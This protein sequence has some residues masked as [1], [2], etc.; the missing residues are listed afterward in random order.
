MCRQNWF[1]YDLR[2]CKELQ[3]LPKTESRLCFYAYKKY[4]NGN[5]ARRTFSSTSHPA[6]HTLRRKWQFQ[7]GN[8]REITKNSIFKRHFLENGW[9]YRREILQDYLEDKT[10]DIF[11]NCVHSTSTLRGLLKIVLTWQSMTKLLPGI[12]FFMEYSAQ[13]LKM[14]TSAD[15]NPR[16]S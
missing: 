8:I 11:Q 10:N 16:Y 5:S 12:T 4:K 14:P 2:A 3:V 1:H 9:S 13:F 7:F 15:R 6:A